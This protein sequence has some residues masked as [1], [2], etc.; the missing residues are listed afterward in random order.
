MIF[1]V[2]KIPKEMENKVLIYKQI[3][4]CFAVGLTGIP[5]LLKKGKQEWG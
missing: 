5:V 4:E 3:S 2:F 1:D